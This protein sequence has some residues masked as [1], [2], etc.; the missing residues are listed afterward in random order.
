MKRVKHY[1]K[2][3]MDV[4]FFGAVHG[5]SLIFVYGFLEW[6][7]KVNTVPFAYI[8]QMWIVGYIISWFQKALFL[9]T[10]YSRGAYKAL[11]I[12]WNIGPTIITVLAQIVLKW[13]IDA[14]LW[15]I[16]L[17]DIIMAL[18][19]IL[20]WIFLEVFYREDT[21]ELNG[22]LQ[23]YKKALEDDTLK[24]GKVWKEKK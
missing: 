18:Y 7:N 4:E 15:E 6:I 11:V 13:F 24:G 9:R 20:M 16:L 2:R 23:D 1:I 19:Y 10:H 3:E 5:L 8:V 22:L 12:A 14:P 17:F 21:N